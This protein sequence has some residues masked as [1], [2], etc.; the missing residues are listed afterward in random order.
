[1]EASRF[2]P[3]LVFQICALLT[4]LAIEFVWPGAWDGLRWA[5][6]LISVSA[7][8]LLLVARYQIGRSFSFTPQARELVTQGIYSRIR[9][10][11]YVFGGFL[12]FGLFLV[13]RKRELLIFLVVM[14]AVQ[15]VRARKEAKVLEQKFGDAYREYR[16]HTWF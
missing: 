11:I 6:L 3:F 16:E 7:S 15:V 1:M 5:G 14:V 8:A 4:V 13:L 2:T 9:N 10:P 12:V